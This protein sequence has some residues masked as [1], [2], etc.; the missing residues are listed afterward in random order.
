MLVAGFIRST[1]PRTDPPP[2]PPKQA[3][4][5]L[6]RPTTAAAAARRLRLLL[7]GIR[8]HLPER[9][10]ISWGPRSVSGQ[11]A[12]SGV[13]VDGEDADHGRVE[14]EGLGPQLCE[15]GAPEQVFDLTGSVERG[16]RGR[17]WAAG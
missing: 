11:V 3:V 16:A 6:A 15:A 5:C 17:P 1:M 2:S 12:V 14:V 10:A 7:Y 4:A 9:D 8:V 13:P